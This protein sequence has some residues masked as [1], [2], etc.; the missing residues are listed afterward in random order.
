MLLEQFSYAMRVVIIIISMILFVITGK[1]ETGVGSGAL[2]GSVIAALAVGILIGV[3]CTLFILTR[4]G[5]K[6]GIVITSAI[7][8][9]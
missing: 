9:L 5:I 7:C 2:I 4:K 8:H 6:T 1:T 3:I